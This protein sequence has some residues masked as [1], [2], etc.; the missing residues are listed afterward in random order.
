MVS[1]CQITGFKSNSSCKD[2]YE[3][4]SFGA[5]WTQILAHADVAG[6][7][8]RYICASLSTSFCS[9]PPVMSVQATFPKPKPAKLKKPCRSG[10][11][12]KVLHLSDLHLGM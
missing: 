9:N 3:A 7:D 6:L 12:V 1:L 2:T 11:R 5:S 4:G 10:K 8:G